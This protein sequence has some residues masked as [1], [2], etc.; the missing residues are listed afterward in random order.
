MKQGPKFRLGIT[1]MLAAA[2]ASMA[3]A[4][5]AYAQDTTGATGSTN[6]DEKVVFT[7]ASTGE[8]DSVNPMTGY[9]AT[10]FYFWTASY[11]LPIDFG[12]DFG[13]EQPSPEFDG[14]NS[15]LVTDVQTSDDS[16]HFTYT[17]RDDL[18][19]SDGEPVT[20]ADVAYTLNLYKDN[21]AYLPQT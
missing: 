21:H 12:L 2:F 9:S 18:F 16:M 15:G 13:S 3:L 17:I 6:D 1:L 19:W 11:H 20:A 14:F 5:A 10:E 4:Q 8:P 7:W